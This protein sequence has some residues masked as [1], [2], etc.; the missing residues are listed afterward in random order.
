M[1]SNYFCNIIFISYLIIYFLQVLG[2]T[3]KNA[4]IGRNLRTTQKKTKTLPKL[5][6]KP[7]AERIQR[8]VGFE[9]VKK[10][11]GKWDAVVTANRVAPHRSFPLIQADISMKPSSAFLS[12]FRIK[13]E[14]EK[15]LEAL[16]PPTEADEDNKQEFPLTLEE[17]IERRK[18][19]AKLRAQQSYREAKARRQN[20]IKSKKFHRYL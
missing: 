9:N 8:A 2:K 5:L 7:Q 20:K 13:T 4:E 11:L 15:E 16:N 10:E 12:K 19:A 6:E 18:E 3:A 1:Y 17:I 14:L